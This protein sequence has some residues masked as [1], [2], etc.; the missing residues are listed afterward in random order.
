MSESRVMFAAAVVFTSLVGFAVLA[1]AAGVTP[2]PVKAGLAVVG[3]LVCVVV[4][5]AESRH[6]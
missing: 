6:L 3:A 4:G 5:W 2:S 1:V